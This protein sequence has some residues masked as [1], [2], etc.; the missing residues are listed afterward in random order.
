MKGK[1]DTGS[2]IF[3]IM[4]ELSNECDAINLSQGFPGFNPDSRLLDMVCKYIQG[5]NNQY[6]PMAGVPALQECI[7]TKIEKFCTPPN[8][9]YAEFELSWKRSVMYPDFPN[10][11]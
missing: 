8:A 6:A 7:A 1:L 5:N 2:S 10:C 11:C 4:T 9:N 3:S